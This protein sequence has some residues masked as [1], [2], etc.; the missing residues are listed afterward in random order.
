MRYCFSQKVSRHRG[1][2]IAYCL[3]QFACVRGDSCEAV[4]DN[5]L[6]WETQL[7]N[8][9][10]VAVPQRISPANELSTLLGKDFLISL[11][12][13]S[14]AV[15]RFHGEALFQMTAGFRWP[16]SS[17]AFTEKFKEDLRG[18]R[19]KT[20]MLGSDSFLSQF[21]AKRLSLAI[22]AR[23]EWI[24]IVRVSQAAIRAGFTEIG[25]FVVRRSNLIEPTNFWAT[26]KFVP[27]TL[28]HL[29]QQLVEQGTYQINAYWALRDYWLSCGNQRTEE[30]LDDY[31]IDNN[32][33]LKAKRE[34]LLEAST[35][36]GCAKM[37]KN[38][39]GHLWAIYGRQVGQPQRILSVSIKG[40]PGRMMRIA[41]PGDTSWQN[42]YKKI[43]DIF[44]NLSPKHWVEFAAE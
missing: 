20:R 17:E 30:E 33:P 39:R 11:V 44:V 3:A 15:E 40:E 16:R 32:A 28:M 2:V 25:F 10:F 43:A 41:L 26:E 22:D 7:A 1:I 27:L 24:D 13:D 19:L 14:R 5:Y 37:I 36:C 42:A 21:P 8:E 4:V 23:V 18:A 31:F 29:N 12:E 38:L 35:E 9:G 34:L 6:Q